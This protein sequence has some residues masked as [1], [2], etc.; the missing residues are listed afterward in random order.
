MDTHT[1][2]DTKQ[3]FYKNF[4]L[5]SCVTDFGFKQATICGAQVV[6]YLLEVVWNMEWLEHIYNLRSNRSMTLAELDANGIFI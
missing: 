2:N 6:V 5:L 4:F 3:D 1:Q